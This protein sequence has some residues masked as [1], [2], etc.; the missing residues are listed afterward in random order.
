MQ[1]LSGPM[2]LISTTL[3]FTPSQDLGEIQGG[4]NWGSAQHAVNTIN[5]NTSTIT[6]GDLEGGGKGGVA[7]GGGSR[8][9]SNA[10]S[11]ISANKGR[12][13]AVT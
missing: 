7:K 8:N 10:G 9:L 12:N 4:Y 6:R 1:A 13:V 11:R 2:N 3:E 5:S